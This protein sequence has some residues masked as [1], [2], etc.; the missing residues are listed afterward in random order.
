M[1]V[2]TKQIKRVLA[3]SKFDNK[4]PVVYA[5]LTIPD[6]NWS[7]LVTDGLELD[8]DWKISGL[9]ITPY[10]PK[11]TEYEMELSKLERYRT[12]EGKRIKRDMTW[13]PIKLSQ[14]YN[15]KRITKL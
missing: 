2:L 15:V 5:K 10:T 14:Y 4:D 7:F 1:K 8:D 3:N 9:M 6:L 13:K 11:G 12:L